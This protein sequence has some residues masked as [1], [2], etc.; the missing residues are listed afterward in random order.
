MVEQLEAWNLRSPE[1]RIQ[2][3]FLSE[4]KGV[5]WGA[6]LWGVIASNYR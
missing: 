4:V 6:C 1:A 3:R 5:F 2:E